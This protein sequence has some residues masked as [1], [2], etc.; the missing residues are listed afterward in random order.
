MV[1]RNEYEWYSH[2]LI[3]DPVSKNSSREK[4]Q[5]PEELLKDH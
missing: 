5:G 2:G 1:E 3:Q 4:E